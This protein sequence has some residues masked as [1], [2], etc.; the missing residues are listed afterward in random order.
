MVNIP[1]DY[2]AQNVSLFMVKNWTVE[3]NKFYKRVSESPEDYQSLLSPTN[4]GVG[5]NGALPLGVAAQG[6][7]NPYSRFQDHSLVQI[8]N[9]VYD[10][11]YGTG[12][13]NTFSDWEVASIASFGAFIRIGTPPMYVLW[14]E[15][16]NTDAAV[17]LQFNSSTYNP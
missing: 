7:D 14:I 10:P 17:D 9:K 12:P 3:P 13:F 16:N 6:N 4:S 1:T 5:V 8:N 11:S 2:I 15:K